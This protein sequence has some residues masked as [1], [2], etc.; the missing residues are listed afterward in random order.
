M[1]FSSG[2][3][4]VYVLLFAAD[5]ETTA[6]KRTTQRLGTRVPCEIDA[7]LTSSD[8]GRSF[9]EP[10]VIVLVNLQGCALKIYRAVNVGSTVILEGLATAPKITGR[11]V[12]SISLGKLERP[13]WL[14]GVAIDKPG[15]VWGISDPPEDWVS[16]IPRNATKWRNPPDSNN[17]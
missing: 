14:L 4:E 10:C 2:C 7:I 17:P 16:S 9:S 8:G 3:K 11:A 5:M 12:S 15:N 1:H 13:F 6:L